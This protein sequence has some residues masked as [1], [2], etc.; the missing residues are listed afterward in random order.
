MTHFVLCD[1]KPASEYAQS[2]VAPHTQVR[3]VLVSVPADNEMSGAVITLVEVLAA[4]FGKGS[5]EGLGVVSAGMGGVAPDSL[6]LWDGPVR[7]RLFG[8]ISRLQT[9]FETQIY[10]PPP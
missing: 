9:C 10:A 4:S 7:R 2:K 8:C 1:V 6:P 5:P 3:T